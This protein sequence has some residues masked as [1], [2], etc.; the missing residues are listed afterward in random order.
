MKS[1]FKY[2]LVLLSGF[3]ILFGGIALVISLASNS[4]P[5]V[6]DN[7]YLY[8]NIGGS[9]SEYVTPDAIQEMLGGGPL[10]L[11]KIR[12]D[13]E[14]AAVDSRIRGVVLNVG[15]LQT[16]FV[17]VHELQEA[18]S[19]YRESGKKIYAYMEWGMTRDY[20]L[21]AA[22]DTI[23]M[24]TSGNLFLTGVGS[25]V[26]HYKDLL[27]KVG[28]KAEFVHVGKY[29][30]A[31][32]TYTHHSMSPENR[33]VLNDILD[34]YYRSIIHN[35]SDLRGIDRAHIKKII[36]EQS[37]L[38]GTDALSEKLVD[39]NGFLDDAVA[40]IRK[41]GPKPTRI[42]ASAYARIPASSLHIRNK[43]RI[44]VIYVNGTIAGG[45]DSDDP[46]LGRITGQNTVVKSLR[47]AASST[48]VKAIVLRIDS[49]GG[50]AIASDVIWHAIK[51]AAAKKPLIASISDMGASGGYFIAAGA[52][53]ILTDSLSLIG[54]IGVFAGKFSLQGL[55]D[56][57]GINVQQ[58]KRGTNAGLFSTNTQWSASER[59]VIARLIKDFYHDFVNKV[60]LG[61]KMPYEKVDHIA[62]GRVWSGASGL[63][64]GLADAPGSFYTAIEFAKK[65]AGIDP[66]ESVR[67]SYY[68][69]KKQL[70]NTLYT[71]ISMKNSF[72]DY[73]KEPQGILM[74][75][76]N[77]PLAMLP[78]KIIWR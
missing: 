73:L 27:V 2:L 39:M 40:L 55:H 20:M 61:R 11:K 76:Q 15:F 46:L 19:R 25:E 57:L 22:C 64:N 29:K 63:R 49:P 51:K 75:L 10:D 58:I 59:N 31:P 66:K 36:N 12:D 78:Y 33:E 6:E 9:L 18:I 26:T 60:S 56:K 23:I 43:S 67:I 50:S 21:A 74:T 4:E 7:S 54:S 1:F 5:M 28:V 53:T 68:P 44:A 37:G 38:T 62:Q 24:P 45:E 65:L 13:L 30:T 34:Q 77:K 69:K 41:D 17:K 32:E 52:D 71:Y 8:I 3:V 72:M 14:K 42:L 16:G 35:I 70:L 47:K 48:S